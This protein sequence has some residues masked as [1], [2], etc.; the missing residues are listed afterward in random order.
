MTVNQQEK[1]EDPFLYVIQ[2]N[3]SVQALQMENQALKTQINLQNDAGHG[4]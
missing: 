4:K 2:L 1:I 3:K